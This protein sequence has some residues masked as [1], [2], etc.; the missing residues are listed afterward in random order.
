MVRV[1]VVGCGYWGPNVVRNLASLEGCEVRALCDSDPGRLASLHRRFPASRAVSS[2]QQILDDPDIDGVAVCT[3]VHTHYPLAAAALQAGK[4]V[5]VE[6]PL[7]DSV[8]TA[9]ILVELAESRGRVLM[10]DH[11]FVYSGAVQKMRSIIDAG[12]LGRLLYFDSVR[13]NLGLFQS[14]INVV[15]DL[16]PHD[17]SIL[18]YLVDQPPQWVS[19]IGTAHYGKLENLA[20]LTIMFEDSLIAHLHL[21]WLAPVKIRSTL[22][23]GSKRMI[24]YD[25]LEPSE[26]IRVY[27]KGVTLQ[28][29]SASR[30]RAMVDY[31]T[32]DMYA[33]YI[34]KDEPLQRVCET[35][36]Q[37]I[38]QGLKP[39]TD[40]RVGLQV[41]RVLEA[42]QQSIRKSGERIAL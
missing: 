35:F 8:E 32:G 18:T 16:A 36:V 31:R 38:E 1:A 24:V 39:A 23:G 30:A 15:W 10:V 21:N 11:T 37:A 7:S 13:V 42:A 25:D 6:K 33:P 29:D 5:L 2:Y 9:E 4:H 19:A 12:E 26:K 17:V 28:S 34:D 22:I 41:V 27:D 14:D 3:P 40:G 20:Y